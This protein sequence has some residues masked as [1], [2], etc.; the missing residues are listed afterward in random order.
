MFLTLEHILSTTSILIPFV[1]GI[2]FY[3]KLGKDL[4]IFLLLLAISVI[5]E[6]IVDYFAFLKINN[7]WLFN[8]Y[9]LIDYSFFMIVFSLWQDNRKIKNTLRISIPV[10][11]IIWLIFLF[12]LGGFL[13]FNYVARYIECII[14]TIVSLYTLYKIGLDGDILVYKD[15]RFWI[16]LG[17]LI[18]F[19]GN[20]F[21]YALGFLMDSEFMD[22]AWIIH[23]SLNITHNLCFAGGFLCLRYQ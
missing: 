7:L 1:I 6:A 9:F 18:Y 8:I 14:F 19:A 13:K 3:R 4:K 21:I 15:Y 17:V 2:F 23:N 20:I 5:V 10:F 22:S 12:I 11:F 16:S